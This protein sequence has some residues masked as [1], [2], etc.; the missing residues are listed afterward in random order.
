M[1]KVGMIIS[2]GRIDTAFTLE[3]IEKIKP[4][5]II[6]VDRGLTFLYENQITPTYGVGDFDSVASEIVEYYKTKNEVS[7]RQFDPE[8]DASDTEIAVKLAVELGIKQLWILGATGTRLD[9]VWA[10]VQTLK[11]AHDAGV[12]AYILDAN[13]R[14]SLVEKEVCLAKENVY[15]N[16]FSIFPLGGS[17]SGLTIEGAKYPLQAHTLSPFDSRC[18]SNEM[19]EKEVRI[20]FPEGIVILMET[21]DE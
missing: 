12:K 16:Y 7:V 5:V 15:G 20:T 8:K 6:G 21:R 19:A 1:N 9:H 3:Q 14:I 18:V 10:N 2:G 11:I 4:E 13:N 17:V